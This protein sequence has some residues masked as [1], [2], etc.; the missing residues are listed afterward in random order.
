V[1]RK[2]LPDTR[3]TNQQTPGLDA[4]EMDDFEVTQHTQVGGFP[5]PVDEILEYRTRSLAESE[6]ASVCTPELEA[7]DTE[8]IAIRLR[9]LLHVAVQLQ[10]RQQPEDV[11]LVET[12]TTRELAYTQLRIFVEDFEQAKSVAHRLDRIVAF[13]LA[14]PEPLLM[15]VGPAPGG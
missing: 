3:D 12:E 14:H 4:V 13:R 7:A 6:A 15:R 1:D 2:A 5:Q 9:A 10:S 11:V 8:T